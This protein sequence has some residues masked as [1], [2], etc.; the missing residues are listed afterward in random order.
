MYLYLSSANIYS[1]SLNKIGEDGEIAGED[2]S[3]YQKNKIDVENEI[4]KKVHPNNFLIARMPSIWGIETYNKSFMFD[5]LDSYKKN[6]VLDS[7]IN[8][9]F[10]FSYIHI[11]NAL[12]ILYG[13][14]KNS[15]GIFNIATEDWASRK[16]LN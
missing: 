5:L 6:L 10:I 14:L 11:K 2:L 1:F 9:E 4:Q 3:I 12:E 16:D 13:L 8:D 7:A 15:S